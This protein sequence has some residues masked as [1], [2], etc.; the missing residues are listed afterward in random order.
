MT[1]VQGDSKDSRFQGHFAE[2]LKVEGK[3]ALREPTGLAMGIG[4]PVILLVVFGLIGIASPGVVPSTR[5]TVLDFYVPT[6]IVI[7]FISAGISSLPVTMVKYREMGWLRRVSTTP[8]PPSR[9]LAAQLIL[10]LVIAL[11]T[12]LI[13]IFGSELVFGAP[14][15]VSVPYFVLSIVLSIATIFSL[16]LVV[17][18]LARSQTVASAL[19]GGLFFLL[20]FLSGLW[21]QPV[22]VGDPLATI[23]YYS[24]SGAAVRAL[25]Y[26]V[27]GSAPPYT[28]VVTMVVYTAV[29][30]YIAN[31]YFRWE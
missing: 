24:P 19:S 14:L 15:E 6:I 4:F 27:F 9:L 11:A 5:L 10:N 2:L 31:R 13:I 30:A 7:G 18:G 28:T 29:F 16:G 8:A 21:I 12:I 17:A 1:S 3:L 23:M 22:L 20:L 26:S 25:L